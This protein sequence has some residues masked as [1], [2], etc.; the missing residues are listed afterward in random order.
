MA[1]IVVV[2]APEPNALLRAAAAPLLVE[3]RP[4][5]PLPLI[6]VRQ[7]ED[8]SSNRLGAG[9]AEVRRLLDAA[10]AE[11]RRGGA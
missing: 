9:L 7:G 3:G 1:R 4:A 8:S 2:S 11:H 6:A 10:R 5:E